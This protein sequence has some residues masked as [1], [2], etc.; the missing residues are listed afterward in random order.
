MTD[1]KTPFDEQWDDIVRGWMLV[2]D[3]DDLTDRI[4]RLA[5]LMGRAK[6]AVA[7]LDDLKAA[8]VKMM[9]DKQIS[10]GLARGDFA[11]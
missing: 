5:E 9:I 2:D 11:P 6:M 4:E 10:E 1:A 7:D 8:T 3:W